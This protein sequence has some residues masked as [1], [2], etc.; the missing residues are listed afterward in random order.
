MVLQRE[1]KFMFLV[2][3][4]WA[5]L[6]DSDEEEEINFVRVKWYLCKGKCGKFAE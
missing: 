2:E 6:P 4:V 3:W 1:R 5:T